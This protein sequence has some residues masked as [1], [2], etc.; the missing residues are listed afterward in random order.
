MNTCKTSTLVVV[1]A[2]MV[3]VNLDGEFYQ[4]SN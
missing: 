1:K 3:T 2:I 4:L